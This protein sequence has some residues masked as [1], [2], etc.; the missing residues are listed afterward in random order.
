MPPKHFYDAGKYLGTIV[1]AYQRPPH[2]VDMRADTIVCLQS[3]LDKVGIKTMLNEL[4]STVVFERPLEESFVKKWQLACQGDIAHVVVMPNITL[5]KLEAFV[6]DLIQ[7]R[8]RV[9]VAAMKQIAAD[10]RAADPE[11]DA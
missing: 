2:L 11:A 10:A 1:V 7:S 3:M 8:A 4:S 6:Q 5:D 9:S